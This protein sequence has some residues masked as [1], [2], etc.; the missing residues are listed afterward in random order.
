M[1]K[2]R[3]NPKDE[4]ISASRVIASQNGMWM[5]HIKENDIYST[6]RNDIELKQQ[7]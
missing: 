6:L 4:P 3:C 7:Y 1:D 5:Q 2:Y